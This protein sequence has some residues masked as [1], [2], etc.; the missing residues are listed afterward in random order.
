MTVRGEAD[1]DE[2]PY[3]PRMHPVPPAPA[4]ITL[5]ILGALL[6]A[7]TLPGQIR[8]S[9]SG[10]WQIRA[11]RDGQ[12][13]GPSREIQVPAAMETALGHDFDGIAWYERNFTIP[14]DWRG[15]TRIEFAAVATH[16][17]V[18]VNGTELGSH[19]GGW[20]TF[21]IDATDAVKPGAANTLVVRVDEKVGHNTQGFLP[22]VQPHFGGIWQDVT[23]CRDAVPVFDRLSA[24][25]FGH[26][27]GTLEY[28]LPILDS[29]DGD[30]ELTVFDGSTL[31]ASAKPA[32]RA[33]EALQGRLPLTGIRRWSPTQPTRYRVQFRLLH[34]AQELDRLE[35]QVGFRHLE[36][37]GTRLL[38]NDSPLQLRGIL[39]WG[40]SPPHLAPPHDPQYWRRQIQDFQA[41]GF[42]CIKCCLWVP[43]RC[44]YELCDELGM[45]VWQE[46]PTWHPKMDQAHKQELLTEYREFYAHDRNFACAAFRSITCE[47]GHGADL[48]VVQT[49]FHACKQ[50]VPNTLVV[51]DS[52]W[53]GWQRITDFWDEHPY[54]NNSWFPGRIEHFRRH[55]RDHGEKPLLLGECIAADTWLDLAAWQRAHGTNKPWWQP[56]CIDAQQQAEAWLTTEFGTDYVAR[57][58]PWSLE[59][60]LRNRKFQIEQLRLRMPD[61]GYVVSVARD[62]PKCRMG[63]YDEHDQAKW[64]TAA[65]AW[66]RDTMLCLDLPWDRRSLPAAPSN[67]PVRISHFGNGELRGKLRLWLTHRP[68]QPDEVLAERHFD[69]GLAPGG[70]SEPFLLPTD[71]PMQALRLHAELTGSH[72]AQNHW[73]LWQ[74]PLHSYIPI[75]Q[76][77]TADR[78]TPELLERIQQGARVLLHAGDRKGSLRTE[79]LWFLRGAPHAPQ[80]PLHQLIPRDLLLELSSFDLE[81]GRVMP[82][83]L[84]RGEV[85]PIL[86]FWETHDIPDVR[87]HLLAF[88]CRIGQGR[89]LATTLNLGRTSPD[90]PHAM[91]EHLQHLM[92]Q[93]LAMGPAATRELSQATIDALRASL[94]EKR[95]DLP[96][97]RFRTDP[98]DEGRAANWHARATATDGEPWRTLR[99]GAHW[100]N[101]AQDLAQYTGIAW[102]RVDLDIPTDWRNLD[103]R[104]VFEGVDDSFDFWL[105]GEHI[106]SHGDPATRHTIWLERQVAELQQRL[107]PGERNTL[108]LRVVDHAGA[109]GLWKPVYL[110]TGPTDA[111][112]RLLH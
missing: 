32:L 51:D 8:E 12:P 64:G 40:Y 85:D 49:L 79:S 91:R 28:Q 90:Q 43:P 38:W 31:I 104:A 88:D 52:S 100:E 89:L 37:Q 59:F 14:A 3:N 102:Y 5:A 21:R 41:L 9:L 26:G 98:Q 56:L 11:D 107:R 74:V 45:L 39:H 86:A 110:T 36:A 78:L 54:G 44:F 13:G 66:H 6:L 82:W 10:S 111:R 61:A 58:L 73:D 72:T 25:V 27:D 18:F 81:T 92:L 30:V 93:H 97:W 112:S 99:A 109:G 33:G 15:K 19:L 75:P 80:H 108:V 24:F 60:G 76:V 34:G 29:K 95:I 68:P 1:R 96:L 50:A 71:W 22:I 105:N 63:L 103:A 87:H 48:D 46:Y 62:I 77:E 20:T 17:T 70:T 83:D 47:T 65:W 53:I 2:S 69:V 84:L 94:T 4:A 7:A 67:I 55:I 42:N 106:S 23:L 57:L 16:A 101:Q 35:F